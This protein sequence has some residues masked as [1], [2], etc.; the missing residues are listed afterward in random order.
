MSLVIYMTLQLLPS[1][2]PYIGGKFNFLFYQCSE[3]NYRFKL[4]LLVHVELLSAGIVQT[5]GFPEVAPHHAGRVSRLL[6]HCSQR[7]APHRGIPHKLRNNKIYPQRWAPHRRIPHKLRNNK[8]YPQRWAPHRRI[9]HKLRNNKTSDFR[10]DGHLTSTNN[11][12]D[13]CN[14]KLPE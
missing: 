14:S 7:W 6:L 2:F 1:E 3:E 13:S 11:E 10:E 4:V 9:P 12:A 8:I 5:G